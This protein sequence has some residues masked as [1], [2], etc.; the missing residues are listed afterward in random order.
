MQQSLMGMS[1][2]PRM[3]MAAAG[4]VCIWALVMW[5]MQ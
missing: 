2:G 1:I 4:V 5:A 3:A